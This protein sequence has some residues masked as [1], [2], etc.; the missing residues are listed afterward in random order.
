MVEIDVVKGLPDSHLS[1]NCGSNA[2]DEVTK[3]NLMISSVKMI[4]I[5]CG[6]IAVEIMM[7]LYQHML[8]EEYL[9]RGK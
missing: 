1:R 2:K 9:E 7:N 3:G 6:K 5:A 4:I 8:V